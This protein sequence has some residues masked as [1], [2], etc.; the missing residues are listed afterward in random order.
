MDMRRKKVPDEEIIVTSP[1]SPPAATGETPPTETHHVDEPPDPTR[2]QAEIE[3]LQR[4]R[5]K[6]EADAKYW[7]EQKAR[8]RAEFFKGKEQPAPQPPVIPQEP[9]LADFEDYDK[10]V[11][12]LVDWKTDQKKKEWEIERANRDSMI[13]R[14]QKAQTF[15]QKLAEGAERYEDFERTVFD[16]S[17]P[18][19]NGMVEILMELDNPAD[20]AY[21]LARNRSEAISISRMT[22]FQAGKAIS[23]IEAEVGKTLAAN[24]DKKKITGAPPPI[25]PL[26]SRETSEKDPEK[27]TGK[28]YEA[29][30]R[31]RGVKMF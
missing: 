23:K 7:R 5:E 29:W 14:T 11:A 27:L 21:Y 6:A 10:Y 18:F 31:G 15:Q 9:K 12:A 4:K 20:V 16:Q 3:E 2:L 13:E 22:P 19:S 30:L 1:E 28:E 24:N 25:T 17:A 8:E 26:G